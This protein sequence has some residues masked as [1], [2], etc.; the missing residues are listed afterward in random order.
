MDW[1]VRPVIVRATGSGT[2]RWRSTNM[3]IVGPSLSRKKVLKRVKE[4]KKASEV[5]ASDSV[6]EALQQRLAHALHRVGG[7]LSRAG[8]PVRIRAVEPAL[9]L[10]ERLRREALDLIRL[11][12]DAAEDERKDQNAE[13]DEA[14]QDDRGAS[15]AGHTVSRERGDDRVR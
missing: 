14:E 9:D 1:I 5:R 3:R 13:G 8:G 7:V 6:P 10:V 15:C 11:L 12:D 2:P 4:R